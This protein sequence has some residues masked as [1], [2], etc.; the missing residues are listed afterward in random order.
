MNI[1]TQDVLNLFYK[2]IAQ[3]DSDAVI[4]MFTDNIY[5]YIVRS[6]KLPWT[7]RWNKKAEIATAL[8]L[9]FNAHAEGTDQLEMDHNFIDGNEAAVFGKISRQVRATGKIFTATFC[10]RFTIKEG[11]ITRFLML[12]DTPEI[13]KAF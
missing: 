9:L 12:E 10:Q 7:G 8:E 4:S 5:W 6:E 1:Q 2:N 3:K 11:K 13:L